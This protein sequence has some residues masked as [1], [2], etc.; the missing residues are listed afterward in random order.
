MPVRIII[1][2]HRASTNDARKPHRLFGFRI[3]EPGDRPAERIAVKAL[4]A[5]AAVDC[6]PADLVDWEFCDLRSDDVGERPTR[7]FLI[8]DPLQE[9]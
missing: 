8:P 2:V 5:A 9:H 1:Q 6:L 7:T 4:T 3:Q